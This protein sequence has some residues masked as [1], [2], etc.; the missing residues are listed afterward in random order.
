MI[1]DS[2]IEV[3][4]VFECDVPGA[5]VAAESFECLYAEVKSF[6]LSAEM[7]RDGHDSIPYA[8]ASFR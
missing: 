8:C 7:F 1:S 5:E 3:D 6:D 4:P 2:E